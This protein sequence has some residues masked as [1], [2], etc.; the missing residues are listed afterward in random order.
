MTVVWGFVIILANMTPNQF[1]PFNTMAECYARTADFI[2]KT[3][4]VDTANQYRGACQ[5]FPK[6]GKSL[7]P[8]ANT[9]WLTSAQ[10]AAKAN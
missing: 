9:Q 6:H 5:T 2:V 4:T 10:L 1:G 8:D 3:E 7:E